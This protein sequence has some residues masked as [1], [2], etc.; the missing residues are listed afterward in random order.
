M[1]ITSRVRG[2]LFDPPTQN[3]ECVACGFQHVTKGAKPTETPMHQCPKH[4]GAWVPLIHAGVKAGVRLNEREDYIGT[5]TGWEDED[6]RIIQSVT[7]VR[8]DGEDCHILAPCSN[9]D[10]RLSQ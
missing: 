10:W 7:T 8:E 6:G 4:K 3:W 9:Y 2:V 5:D 1:S